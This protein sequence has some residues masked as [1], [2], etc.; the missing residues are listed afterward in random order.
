[1]NTLHVPKAINV[2]NALN[3]IKRGSIS[4]RRLILSLVLV[5]VLVMGGWWFFSPAPPPPPAPPLTH[6][7]VEINRGHVT[8][9]LALARDTGISWVR[10]NAI[11]WSEVE[12]EPGKR[13]W[14]ALE[15]VDH[16]L[17]T[18]TEHGFTPTV[19]IRG[20]PEWA[21]QQ[22]E[23]AC[24]PIK[25]EALDDFADF[26][27]DLVKRY[28]A[29][30]YNVAY[31]EVWNEPDVDPSL[32]PPTF[33]YGCWGDQDDPFYGGR[34]FAEMLAMAYS[35]I[36]EANPNAQVILGGLALDCDPT[37]PPEGKPPDGCRSSLFLEGI[38][39]NGGAEHF[40]ILAYHSYAYW[41]G[42]WKDWEL[43]DHSWVHRGG[44][45]A[46]RLDYLQTLL[47]RH[48]VEKP[49]LL[50]EGSL[51]CYSSYPACFRYGYLADQ[52]SYVI[53]FYTRAWARGIVGSAWYSLNDTAWNE[54]GTLGRGGSI[55]PAYYA[56]KF[57]TTLLHDT[58]YLGALGSG[59]IEGYAF[60]KGD[61][62]YDVY[63]T[64]TGELIDMPLPRS[65]RIVYNHV[66]HGITPRGGVVTIS[67][68][69]IVIVHRPRY[70]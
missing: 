38:L 46:G 41:D 30:P 14:D 35:A 55:R 67:D 33:P 44:A 32:I 21:Q 23:V 39:Q 34:Y 25:P 20:T 27:H 6:F 52:A 58:T 43:H 56:L 3:A 24:G 42:R 29:P 22:D 19:I 4:H 28:S 16:E 63:W 11:L 70:W 48:Q 51:L 68:E 40:D 47:A 45:M 49:I 57:I 61:T 5:V 26:V 65:T 2:L 53:R 60:Y 37:H 31:W 54:S 59:D 50:N 62:R 69:P 17:Q 15:T 9:S 18:L 7:G 36:K 1:M 12:P 10:Y 66:G 8:R 13:E 64:N